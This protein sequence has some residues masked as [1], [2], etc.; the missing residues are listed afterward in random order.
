M[1]AYA[2][3]IRV[4]VLVYSKSLLHLLHFILELEVPSSNLLDLEVSLR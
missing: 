1:I 3:R 4:V 2:S